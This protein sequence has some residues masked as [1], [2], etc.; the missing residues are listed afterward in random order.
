VVHQR[1]FR[2]LELGDLVIGELIIRLGELI[3]GLAALAL[4]GALSRFGQ[5]GEHSL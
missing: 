5:P 4:A 1:L 3:M 2:I